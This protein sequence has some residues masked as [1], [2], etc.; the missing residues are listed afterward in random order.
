VRERKTERQ[1]G[2]E[3]GRESEKDKENRKKE[4]LIFAFKFYFGLYI[5]F[6]PVSFHGQEKIFFLIVG[7]LIKECR[8]PRMARSGGA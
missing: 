3:T 6:F 2:K 7:G 1:K 4:K 8:A 5:C